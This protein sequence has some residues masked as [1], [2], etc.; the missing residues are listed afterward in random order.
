MKEKVLILLFI[1]TITSCN[2][3][4]EKTR[5]SGKN[6]QIEFK[7][8][9][10]IKIPI[11]SNIKYTYN[12]QQVIENN[13]S[14][15][16]IT[17]NLNANG[18]IIFDLDNKKIMREINFKRNGPNGIEGS[19]D[20]RNFY[21]INKDSIFIIGQS[22]KKIFLTNINLTILKKINLNNLTNFDF[23]E[24]IVESRVPPKYLN[25]QLMISLFPL[26]PPYKL[27][28][29]IEDPVSIYI[30]LNN[31][32]VKKSK[33]TFNFADKKNRHPV[34]HYP[35]TI[36]SDSIDLYCFPFE[37]KIYKFD[38]IKE[39]LDYITFKSEYLKEYTPMLTGFDKMNEYDITNTH[40]QLFIYD[41]YNELYY[42]F[43]ELGI[44][45]INENTGKR[46]SYY[47]KPYSLIVFN[48]NL[49][50]LSEYKIAGSNYIISNS[51]VTK[52]GLFLFKNNPENKN[53][54]DENYY[55]YD[56]F[57]LNL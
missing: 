15:F 8:I 31:E 4:K 17:A 24:A 19:K 2:D 56:V 29:N 22:T 9:D 12:Y 47:N 43:I 48:K 46:N 51:F 7:I 14:T 40:N 38:K 39:Q 11:N 1:I 44:P 26:T 20:G 30:D 33:L 21:Y 50:Q 55:K 6:K 35:T 57:K 54:F 37:N 28:E 49:K 53:T 5:L 32:K 34:Y 36:F 52:R 27:R 41:K 16:L 42:L 10:S 25:N 23:G 45:L 13:D 3:T 18:F